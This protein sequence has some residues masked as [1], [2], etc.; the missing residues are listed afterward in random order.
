MDRMA[1]DM[2]EELRIHNVAI[3]SLWPGATRTELFA[4][5][6][7][8]GKFEHSSDSKVVRANAFIF[9][10]FEEILLKV[11]KKLTH[12]AMLKRQ[13]YLHHLW[14]YFHRNWLSEG[15]QKTRKS[16]TRGKRALKLKAG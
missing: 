13:C 5:M 15:I 9:I 14:R 4:K 7:D 1:I 16:G 6:V 10:I 12:D 2:A 3:V 8:S 11:G